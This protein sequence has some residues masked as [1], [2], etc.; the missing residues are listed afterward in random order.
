MDLF[1]AVFC[2]LQL[3]PALTSSY[4]SSHLFS[5]PPPLESSFPVVVCAI[6]CCMISLV[7]ILSAFQDQKE[8]VVNLTVFQPKV[9]KHLLFN[10]GKKLADSGTCQIL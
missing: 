5:T 10:L 4:S 7:V 1:V 2:G 3:V 9:S 6:S 8:S